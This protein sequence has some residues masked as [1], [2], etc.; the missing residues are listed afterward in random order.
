MLAKRM[1]QRCA[2]TASRVSAPLSLSSVAGPRCFFSADTAAPEKDSTVRTHTLL[3]IRPPKFWT[4]P[5]KA[6]PEQDP[7]APVQHSEYK[8]VSYPHLAEP[9]SWQ[10]PLRHT[11]YCMETLDVPM[12]EGNMSNIASKRKRVKAR[13]DIR[14]QDLDPVLTEYQK[15]IFLRLAGRR[16]Q[17]EAGRVVLVSRELPTLVVRRLTSPHA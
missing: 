14:V 10:L 1:V 15:E 12:I 11:M 7:L 2:A 5:T 4:A 13:L 17:S 16:Y 3:A 6:C 9:M 8:F